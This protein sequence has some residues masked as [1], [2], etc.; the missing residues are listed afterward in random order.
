MKVIIAGSRDIKDYDLVLQAVQN[1]QREYGSITEVVSG[2]EP[3]GVDYMGEVWA[4]GHKV[5]IKQFPPDWKLGRR[6]GP[7]R[8]SQMAEYAE[9][10]IVI[11]H[12][13]SGSLDMLGKAL[14][15]SLK[16]HEVRL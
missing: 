2:C 11:H 4:Q 12:A 1:F 5:P 16:V 8:N 6:G 15:K 13:S 9:G 14:R 3:R 10:L 7:I